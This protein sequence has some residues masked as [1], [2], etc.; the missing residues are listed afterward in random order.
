MCINKLNAFDVIQKQFRILEIHRL[1]QSR[2]FG[3]NWKNVA[4]LCLILFQV[5]TVLLFLAIEASTNVE[6]FGSIFLA[7][8]PL[9]TIFSYLSFAWQINDILKLIMDLNAFATRRKIL[10]YQISLYFKKN[11][12][13]LNV[14]FS[15][16]KISS[17][18]KM[19][20]KSVHKISR[21]M[22]KIHFGMVRLTLNFGFGSIAILCTVNYIHADY[23]DSQLALP[24]F[25]W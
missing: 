8:T 17:M 22:Q 12:S 6:Y 5:V 21:F 4:I 2:K 15:G 1:Q 25:M 9:T 24:V 23:D 3:L 14:I 19:Y 20:E 11:Q 13:K 16:S 7:L 10:R 18:K